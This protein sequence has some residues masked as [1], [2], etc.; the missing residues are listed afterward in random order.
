VTLFSY[1]VRWD[2][3]FAPNPFHGI[4][5][6][7][8]CKPLIRRK[9]K[10]G[11]WVLGTGSAERK[12]QG[13]AIF[14]MHIDELS[15]FDDYW[16][17]PRF[18]RKRPTMNGSLKQRFGDNI[19]HHD[20]GG[21]WVQADSRHSRDGHANDKN[22]ARDTNTTDRV[23]IASDFMYWGEAAPK[24]PKSLQKF[25]IARPGWEENFT[26]VEIEQLVDWAKSHEQQGQVGDPLE[27]QYER[28]WR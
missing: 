18:V 21:A 3:G 2:H 4:C 8:T 5:T 16:M 6:L 25:V 15:R 26:Q 22:L 28:W 10:I 12:F 20:E 14:L 23:L 13:R 11:D 27:W 17:N 7:A 19:Y 1:V 9:A 24:I